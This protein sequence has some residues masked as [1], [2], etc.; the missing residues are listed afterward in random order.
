M[1]TSFV[2]NTID[3]TSHIEASIDFP[4]EDIEILSDCNLKERLEKIIDRLEGLINS[5]DKGMILMEGIRTVICGRPNV[6]KSS[7]M[8][9]LLKQKRVIVSHIPG[10]TRDVIEEIRRTAK[11]QLT[12]EGAVT[13]ESPLHHRGIFVRHHSRRSE[14]F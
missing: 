9:S 1:L 12:R 8:N 4:D 3:L 13:L 11:I 6:G 14:V 5:A 10:T 7:L 2:M